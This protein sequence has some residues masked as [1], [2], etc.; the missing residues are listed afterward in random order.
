[1]IKGLRTGYRVATSIRTFEGKYRAVEMTI[2]MIRM[3]EKPSMRVVGSFTDIDERQRA[4]W[5]LTEAERKY[6]SIWENSAHGIYQ[7]TQDGQIISANPAM[8]RIFGY[9]LLK[10]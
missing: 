10:R 7:V 6:R 8:A 9:D 5:A 4:E 3:D 2:S 1:M